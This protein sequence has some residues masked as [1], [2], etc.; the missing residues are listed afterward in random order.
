[1][2]AIRSRFLHRAVGVLPRLPPILRPPIRRGFGVKSRRI[3]F[4]KMVARP[5]VWEL[6]GGTCFYCCGT[7]KGL[8][9]RGTPVTAKL[10]GSL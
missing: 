2:K 10:F 4:T 1:M 6:D 9:E 7:C 5:W 8:P 3:W